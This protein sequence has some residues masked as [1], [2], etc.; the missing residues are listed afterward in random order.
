MA[1]PQDAYERYLIKVEKNITNDNTSTSRGLFV[2]VFNEEQNKYIENHLQQ[3]GID[4]VRYIE[5]FLILDKQI[6]YS[7]KAL[8][9]YNFPFP[10]N[11]LDLAEVRAIAKQ[12]KCK[13]TLFLY[14]A[15]PENLNVLLSDP[16]NK[17]S[18]KWRESL[19]TTNSNTVSVY[20]EK[21]FEITDVLLSYYRYPAKISLVNPY[22]PESEFVDMEI[23]WDDKSL[24]RIISMCATAFD[25]N[26][27]NPRAQ[28][29]IMRTQK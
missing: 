8:N 29:Q 13:D 1:T 16:D 20:G 15:R 3:R 9:R 5:N 27:N 10:D 23:E 18:F 12:E 14:E 4:D 26:E 17:P 19:F 21:D 2:E 22:D 24:N 11:Y 7:S 28:A 6:P 25:L